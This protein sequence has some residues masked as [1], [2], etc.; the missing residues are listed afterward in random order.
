MDRFTWLIVGGVLALVIASLAVATVSRGRAAQPD[1]NTPSGVVL[2]YAQAELRGDGQTAWELL[3]TST[4][5]RADRD[6]FIARVGSADGT[7]RQY[8]STEAEHIDPDNTASVTLV[9]TIPGSGG[10]FGNSSYTSHSVVRLTRE[11]GAW[12]ITVPPDE[13]ALSIGSRNP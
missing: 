10:L 4:R 2:A 7:P 6:R 3:A 1:L 13:F 8:L 9:R 5:A 11:A 12:R